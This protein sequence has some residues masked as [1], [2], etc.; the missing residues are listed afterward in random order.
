M[1]PALL[2]A[3]QS[4]AVVTVRVDPQHVVRRDADRVVGI[5]TNYLRDADANRPGARPFTEAL[6]E[7]QPRW[8]RYPGGE[9]SDWHLWSQPPYSAAK[10][11]S[12]GWYA[13]VAG[14]RLDF[15]AYLRACLAT[16][17]EPL[18][19]VGYDS[20]ER[21][22]RTE[23]EYLQDAA[24]WVRYA[25]T[26]EPRVRHWEIGNENWHND[27][28]TPAHMARVIA[29]F[30]KAMRAE[31]PEILLGTN[32]NAK[33]WW[34]ALLPEASQHL[35]FLTLSQY[36]PWDWGSYDRFWKLPPPDLI[37]SLRAALEAAERHPGRGGKPLDV[38]VTELNSKDY[39]PGG[40]PDGN[41]L[42]HGLVTFEILGQC[43]LQPQ[44]KAAMIWNTRWVDDD[45]APTS[46]W[47]A[48]GPKNELLPTGV[49]LKLWSGIGP[50]LVRAQ[51]TDPTVAAYASRGPEGLR[52]WVVNRSREP[53]PVMFEI[54][55]CHLQTPGR[56]W[57]GDSPDDPSPT[58]SDWAG[59]ILPPVSVVLLESR[60]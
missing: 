53:K 46:Q 51:T 59:S 25:K 38:I 5:N 23:E 1:L 34:D 48:L 10:P 6:S 13:N 60:G 58:V 3:I 19:V 21:T 15:D 54:D 28:A 12:L 49:A 55:G 4:P 20:F 50:E 7:L 24:A 32:G 16:G 8:L 40:W 18:V 27:S 33:P 35:D 57:T 45:E 43:L 44:V 31:D 2:L 41:N 52:V 26:Q 9:K 22:G 29:R 30:S 11:M 17:A 14:E 39:G 42:G 36:S 47:Y 37:G 56:V